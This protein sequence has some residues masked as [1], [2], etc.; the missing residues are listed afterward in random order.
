MRPERGMT[1]LEVLVALAVFALAGLAMVRTVTG[2]M[3]ALGDMEE[4][5][6]ATWVADNQLAELTLAKRWPGLDWTKG[7][8]KMAGRTW[9]WRWQGVETNDDSFRALDVEVR[10]EEAAANARATLRTYVSR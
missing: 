6:L 10:T 4:K 7:Q 1:L 8:E 2:Q 9:Y 5:T 3:V